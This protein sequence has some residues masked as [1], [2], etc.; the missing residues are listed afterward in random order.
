[1]KV[2]Y[3][4][5]STKKQ[6]LNRQLTELNNYG[7]EKIFQEQ[8]SGKNTTDREQFQEA[9]N[10]VREN[11]ELCVESLERL[12]RSYEDVKEVVQI[13]KNKKVRLVVT[14]LPMLTESFENPL[15]DTFVKDLIIQ[16]LAMI[17]QQEREEMIRKT[18][19]G[20]AR[21]KAQGR[22]K[23]RPQLYSANSKDKQKQLVYKNVV[24]QLEENTPIK[25][26]AE[27]NGISRPTVYS[28]KN[29]INVRKN[30]KK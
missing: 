15:L 5:T 18:K 3:A 12:G 4:R 20:V 21:A 25:H 9:L 7:C 13:L 19:Q 17:G 30:I 16:I 11:D 29:E 28:I 27:S 6:D 1:M 10:F 2:G 26:I 24:K 22:M 14:S 23:G 8:V